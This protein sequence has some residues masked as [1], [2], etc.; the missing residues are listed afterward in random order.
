MKKLISISLCIVLIC[1]TIGCANMQRSKKSANIIEIEG[2]EYD[3][4]QNFEEVISSMTKNGL[5]IA[6]M[7]KAGKVYTKEGELTSIIKNNIDINSINLYVT[8]QNMSQGSHHLNTFE[9]VYD[10]TDFKTVDNITFK[11]SA[12]KLKDLE[13][14]TSGFNINQNREQPAYFALYED[15]ELIDLTKYHKMLKDINIDDQETLMKYVHEE[16]E[17]A[18]YIPL[19]ESELGGIAEVFE[20]SDSLR[21]H[22]WMLELAAAEAIYRLDQGEISSI[23]VIRYSY[24]KNSEYGDSGMWTKY[25][26]LT[27]AEDEKTE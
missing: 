7:I 15:G 24:V 13:E 22:E 10:N 20:M 26:I 12:K 23:T 5:I 21:L 19:A 4:S 18:S 6:D 11:S 9:F 27:L 3:L 2:H 1:S 16:Y 25:Q 17:Y 8:S 14:Y